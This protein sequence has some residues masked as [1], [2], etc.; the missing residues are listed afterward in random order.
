MAP[1]ANLIETIP[2]SDQLGECVLWRDSDQTVWWTDVQACRLHRLAWPSLTLT[3]FETPQR[4]CSF[5]FLE[6]TDTSILAAFESGIAVYE[7]E[8]NRTAWLHRPAELRGHLRLN[9]GRTD[10]MGRFWVGSMSEDLVPSGELY[11]TGDTSKLTSRRRNI[12]ISNGICW[13]PDGQ[14]M[15]FTDSPSQQ[16]Q[17]CAYD[18]ATGSTGPWE[19][20]A[21]VAVGEPDGAIT[22]AQG[23]Y[24][25]AHWGGA[26]IAGIASDGKQMG[27]I[28][29]PTPNP[30]CPALGGPSGRLL[31]VTSA[32]QG[33]DQSQ[34]NDN[35]G[36]LHVFET[37]LQAHG[38]ANVRARISHPRTLRT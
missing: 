17:T 15:Y 24:W 20:F 28:D 33:L 14:R 21:S 3:T 19:P 1:T 31:F 29:V 16:I 32:R 36:A 11:C 13:A 18:P 7:P 5:G 22:D 34:L 38:R 6:G 23:T 30:T 35:A 9:D 37:D 12:R 10:P 27:Q 26:R 25:F 2:V 8:E 4:L